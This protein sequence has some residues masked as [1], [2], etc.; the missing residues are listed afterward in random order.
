MLHGV[1]L[2]F[3]AVFAKPEESDKHRF[4]VKLIDLGSDVALEQRIIAGRE[5]SFPISLRCSS[6]KP[7][8]TPIHLLFN[9]SLP[10]HDHFP[11]RSGGT[12]ATIV[13]VE[14]SRCTGYE[15]HVQRENA[16]TRSACTLPGAGCLTMDD[17]INGSAHLVDEAAIGDHPPVS[18]KWGEPALVYKHNSSGALQTIEINAWIK[19]CLA[20]LEYLIRAAEISGDMGFTAVTTHATPVS[21]L[22]APSSFHITVVFPKPEK[23]DRHR[24]MLWVL[25]RRSLI[26]AGA[27]TIAKREGTFVASLRC[28]SVT[29]P[30]LDVGHPFMMGWNE[31]MAY[32]RM[33]I[34]QKVAFSVARYGDGELEILS[35]RTHHNK[36]WSWSPAQHNAGKFRLAL[37][38]PFTDAQ[39]A[40][41]I[42]MVGLPVPFCA[43]GYVQHMMGGG[44]RTD[45]LDKFFEH[46]AVRNV[47]SNRL[48]YS[49]Q[50]G[51]LNY[52]AT[53]GLIRTLREAEW[54]IWV[55]CNHARTRGNQTPDWVDIVL[56]VS[57]NNIEDMMS[58]W[59]LITGRMRNW[60]LAV[61]KTAFLFAAG[62]ISNVVISMMH[63]T[64]PRN[65][66]ID[67][68]G[69]LDY[70][71]SNDRTRDFHPADG[72][73]N[74]FIRAGG[75]LIHGQNCTETRY[76]ITKGRLIPVT[77][78][79][80]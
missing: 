45:L 10:L 43:E 59:D 74:H 63:R 38:Q 39:S 61:N 68:G 73:P 78:V 13:S 30:K 12:S 60:A 7:S 23:R 20:D 27:E 1:T 36:E 72:D 75:A 15:N 3:T 44:G 71:L 70:I 50:F 29:S 25:D 34:R 14:L 40:D 51:N 8:L 21:V 79:R 48:L 64:N 54:P 26:T 35:N 77:D 19:G 31:S 76:V 69:S 56:T 80:I 17:L 52:N 58:D 49:W 11:S 53:Q 2:P 32:L 5:G 55:V 47:P 67:V 65:I 16:F 66:Y 41:N 33:L 18:I 46:L 6:A 42:M 28:P 62:P 24:I 22:Q 37:M 4:I 9:A 57:N